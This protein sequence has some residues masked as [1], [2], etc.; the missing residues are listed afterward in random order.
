MKIEPNYSEFLKRSNQGNVIPVSLELP[1]DLET[2]VSIFLKLARK[3]EHT[4][5]LESVE[6]ST[7]R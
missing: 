6:L 1:A 7:L 3:K 5:L 2:P 4:F